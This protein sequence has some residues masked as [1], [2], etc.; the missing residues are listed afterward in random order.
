MFNF[1]HLTPSHEQSDE[2]SNKKF[3]KD[4]MPDTILTNEVKRHAILVSLKAKQ[5]NLENN[6]DELATTRKRKKQCQCSADSLRTPEFVRR[7]H[8]MMDKNAG[9]SMSD[10]LP[11]IFKCLRGQPYKR[12]VIHQDILLRRYQFM[13][14]KTTQENRLMRAKL[15]LN[16]LKHPEE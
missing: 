5:S 14:T 6:G 10:I 13:S 8:D 11:K 7:V 15:L 12:N 16:K 3:H 2:I 4:L 9:K 1:H